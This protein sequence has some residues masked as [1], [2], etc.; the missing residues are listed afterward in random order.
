MFHGMSSLIC[1]SQNNTNDE[2]IFESFKVNANSNHVWSIPKEFLEYMN[3]MCVE[4]KIEVRN[5]PVV[6]YERTLPAEYNQKVVFKKQE[7][8]LVE[9]N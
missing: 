2:K 9:K 6:N 4:W 1:R 8:F 3:K 5:N 7:R